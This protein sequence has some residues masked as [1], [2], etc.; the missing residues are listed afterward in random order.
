MRRPA[1]GRTY[2]V[3]RQIYFSS[4]ANGDRAGQRKRYRLQTVAKPLMFVP[5]P[6]SELVIDILGDQ[7]EV[8]NAARLLANMLKV[9]WHKTPFRRHREILVPASVSPQDARN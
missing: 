6:A 5:Q 1:S 8:A 9:P 3:Q 2:P 4:A 7:P